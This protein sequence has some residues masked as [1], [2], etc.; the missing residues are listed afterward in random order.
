MVYPDM[1]FPVFFLLLIMIP[2]SLEQS[3]I[4]RII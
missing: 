2:N 4:S 1:P 3:F